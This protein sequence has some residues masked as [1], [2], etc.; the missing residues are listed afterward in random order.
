MKLNNRVIVVTGGAHGIGRAMCL[1]FAQERPEA[2]V[3]AD[4]DVTKAREVANN[5]DGIAVETDV[6]SDE[7]IRNLVSTTLQRY[8]RID[9]FCS[10]AGI[11]GTG[12]GIEVPNAEWQLFL[13]INVLAHVYAARAVIPSMLERGEG[14]LLQTVS[15][16]GLL[17]QIGSAPYTVSKHAAMAFA[18]WLSV[19]YCDAGIRV[20]ALC[21]QGVRTRMLGEAEPGARAFLHSNA[22]DPGEVAEMVVAGI[23][24]ERFLILPHP[25]VSEY[26]RRKGDDYERWLRGM[27]KL[28]ERLKEV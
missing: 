26:V 18:E 10:N 8:G 21:P 16:A 13:E 24:A 22:L 6:G 17:M 12:G 20:S 4:L 9:V 27:R 11:G 28:K 5:I 2:I 3:V 14:Y 23:D 15:A 19:T 1:R 25:E 7:S